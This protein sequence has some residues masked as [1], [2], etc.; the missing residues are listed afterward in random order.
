[1][2]YATLQLYKTITPRTTGHANLAI[3]ES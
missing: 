3:T 2:Y 1:M